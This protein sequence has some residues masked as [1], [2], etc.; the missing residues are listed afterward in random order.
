MYVVTRSPDKTDTE[1]GCTKEGADLAGT[2]GRPK[3][4]EDCL[5]QEV[6]PGPEL[7]L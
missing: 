7:Q 2:D 4:L 6:S 5:E 1:S 3:A